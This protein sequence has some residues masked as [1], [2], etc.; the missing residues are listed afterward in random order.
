M[1]IAEQSRG[2]D[3]HEGQLRTEGKYLFLDTGAYGTWSDPP[4]FTHAAKTT[5]HHANAR[6]RNPQQA[7]WLKHSLVSSG[8][9]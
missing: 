2:L 5:Q 3:V 7:A 8:F 1:E 6:R 4:C 9:K